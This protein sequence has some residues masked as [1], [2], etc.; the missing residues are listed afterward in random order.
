MSGHNKWSKI[1]RQKGASDAKRGTMF[2]KLGRAISL[3]VKE[4][5]GNADI[6]S[7][8]KLRIAVDQAKQHNMP[9]DNIARAIDRGSGRGADMGTLSSVLYEGYGPHG[10]ALIIEAV[11]DNIQ[12]TSAHVKHVLSRV[13]GSLGSQGSV[14]FQ[15]K[16]QGLILVDRAE[17]KEDQIFEKAIESGAEDMI[18]GE[19]GFE[20]YTDRSSLHTVKDSLVARGVEVVSSELVYNPTTTIP[21]SSKQVD[22]IANCV[23]QLEDLDDVQRV[24]SNDEL[25]K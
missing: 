14:S 6:D 12:R 9:K 7:N 17:N 4:S 22:S 16:H 20:I 1:K 2:T 3:A 21:L 5:G 18:T 11:T 25:S 13:G 19:E 10:V 8:F 24:F 15:F 23:E